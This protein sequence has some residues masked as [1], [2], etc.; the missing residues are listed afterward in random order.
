MDQIPFEDL[1]TQYAFEYSKEFGETDLLKFHENIV[2]RVNWV[3]KKIYDEYPER[4]EEL[5]RRIEEQ[6][7]EM[8]TRYNMKYPYLTYEGIQEL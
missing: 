8:E 6:K 7:D 3:R 2:D 5:K 1:C 4:R